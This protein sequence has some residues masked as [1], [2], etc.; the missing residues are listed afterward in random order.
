MRQ[1]AATKPA[2]KAS[3]DPLE[4]KW[5][6]NIFASNYEPS[7]LLPYRREMVITMNGDAC[8]QEISSWRRPQ[9]NGWAYTATNTT[10]ANSEVTAYAICLAG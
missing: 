5:V 7:S 4:G 1:P 3:D 6:L 8:T 9:G 2:K 10:G